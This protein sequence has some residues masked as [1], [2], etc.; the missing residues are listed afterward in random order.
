MPPTY[1][2]T[3]INPKSLIYTLHNRQG[4]FSGFHFLIFFVNKDNENFFISPGTISQIFGPRCASVS[5]PCE[6]FLTFQV[7]KTF[8]P[9]YFDDVFKGKTEFIISG[10]RPYQ[11]LYS[12]IASD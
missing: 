6:T 8:S 1:E 4:Q 2:V 7:L 9:G 10:D 3:L 5:V 12:S 11:T